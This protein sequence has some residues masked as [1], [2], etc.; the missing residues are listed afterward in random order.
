MC[1]FLRVCICRC[2]VRA[3]LCVVVVVVCDCGCLFE[4]RLAPAFALALALVLASALALALAFYVCVRTC[5]RVGSSM[6]IMVWTC[7]RLA[8]LLHFILLLFIFAICRCM[9]HGIRKLHLHTIGNL[10]ACSRTRAPPRLCPLCSALP[11]H[12]M[13]FRSRCRLRFQIP[14]VLRLRQRLHRWLCM[15]CAVFVG[16]FSV[17]FS[18]VVFIIVCVLLCT[19]FCLVI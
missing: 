1:V 11:R 5:V 14:L 10:M 8:A 13:R 18:G 17:D 16:V 9:V 12:S 15:P 4:C 19:F 6:L 3:R 2:C 7:R